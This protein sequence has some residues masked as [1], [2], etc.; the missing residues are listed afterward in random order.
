MNI[1]NKI[2]MWNEVLLKADTQ[3]KQVVDQTTGG[4][5][6]EVAKY[7]ND[8]SLACRAIN[9][10]REKSGIDLRFSFINMGKVLFTTKHEANLEDFIKD[11][12]FDIN[13]ENFA[14]S[15]VT[16]KELDAIKRS[17]ALDKVMAKELPILSSH[18]IDSE[19]WA[20]ISSVAKQQSEHL[21]LVVGQSR[22]TARSSPLKEITNEVFKAQ[23][24][25]KEISSEDKPTIIDTPK[26]EYK[27]ELDDF[28][29]ELISEFS[30]PEHKNT[31]K[32]VK[33]KSLGRGR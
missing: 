4:F 25:P 10:I 29:K 30:K 5:Y 17:N 8:N 31:V 11:Y 24:N 19:T 21:K 3:V 14:Y 23:R 33:S 2:N 20:K 9:K 16:I 28:A 13:T 7:R 26:A 32:I 18:T 12:R 22:G 1:T 27:V 6:F 15:K